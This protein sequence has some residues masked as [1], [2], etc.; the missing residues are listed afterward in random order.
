MSGILVLATAVVVLLVACGQLIII[1]STPT[2]FGSSRHATVFGP[3]VVALVI[4]ALALLVEVGWL[5][6]NL[7]RAPRLPMWFIPV[8]ALAVA[9]A[10]VLIVASLA[11]PSY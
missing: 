10:S 3:A 4:S 1:Y 8:M 11:Q 5:I 6:V 2:A 7:R 9:I